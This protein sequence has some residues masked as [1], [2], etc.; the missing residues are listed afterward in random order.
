MS[1]DVHSCVCRHACVCIPLDCSRSVSF[2]V[3]SISIWSCLLRLRNRV[4]SSGCRHTTQLDETKIK[5]QHI[6]RPSKLLTGHIQAIIMNIS[7]YICIQHFGIS[8]MQH[9]CCNWNTNVN[10]MWH[11]TFNST[12]RSL[13][14]NVAALNLWKDNDFPGYC[15]TL[16]FV[17]MWKSIK[18]N[19]RVRSLLWV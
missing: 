4:I 16:A 9:F 2:R 6:P 19:Y 15:W 12:L 14:N 3:Q 11:F 18:L 8:I 13:C 1:S 5:H 7:L 10:K 17:C